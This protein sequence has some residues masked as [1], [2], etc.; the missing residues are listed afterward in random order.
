MHRSRKS[1]LSSTRGAQT[2]EGFALVLKARE[3]VETARLLRRDDA[4]GV[5]LDILH[6][7]V[8]QAP[9]PVP[10]PPKV[11][12]ISGFL[13][14]GAERANGHCTTCGALRRMLRHPAGH[15]TCADCLF[16]DVM[17]QDG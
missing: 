8:A 12:R 7:L 1:D 15:L 14:K 2:R 11:T 9:A 4:E 13:A 10:P 16:D 6:E 3:I 5:I 17:S